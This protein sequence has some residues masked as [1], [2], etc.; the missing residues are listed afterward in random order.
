MGLHPADH[1]RDWEDRHAGVDGVQCA[2]EVVT[3][4]Q[5]FWHGFCIGMF[6]GVVAGIGIWL[7]V[8]LWQC[9]T[10]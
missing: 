5:C 7:A 3:R 6:K 1:G 4:W 8:L 2:G 9:A 10:N